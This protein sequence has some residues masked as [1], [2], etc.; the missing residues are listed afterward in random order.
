MYR[1]REAKCTNSEICII[2]DLKTT[3]LTSSVNLSTRGEV[4]LFALANVVGTR[5]LGDPEIIS[6]G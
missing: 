1:R 4:V 2:F 6:L 5:A 3:Q